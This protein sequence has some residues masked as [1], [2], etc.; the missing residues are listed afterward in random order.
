M[1]AG[2]VE[3]VRHSSLRL[4]A[5]SVYYLV[6]VIVANKRSVK[7][8]CHNRHSR[9]STL[10]ASDP[11]C[12]RVIVRNYLLSLLYGRS[13]I[14]FAIK[15]GNKKYSSNYKLYRLI[16]EAGVS[17]QLARTCCLTVELEVRQSRL[18]KTMRNCLTSFAVYPLEDRPM[19]RLRAPKIS[20][21]DQ[22]PHFVFGSCFQ[23]THANIQTS[24]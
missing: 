22:P 9:Y 13:A 11:A 15:A 1:V 20:V 19:M 8:Q 3:P 23:R 5:N 12:N 24:T 4:L 7:Q 10:D 18:I 6:N 16:T 17:E 2:S 21:I 14:S